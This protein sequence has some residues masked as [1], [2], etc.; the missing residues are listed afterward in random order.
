M[1]SSIRAPRS[2]RALVSPRAQR[3]ASTRLLL[4]LPLGPTTAVIPRSST[5]SVRRAKVLK[6]VT[7]TR[8]NLIRS[9]L[10][11]GHLAIPVHIWGPDMDG[12]Q[13]TVVTAVLHPW[14]AA[15]VDGGAAAPCSEPPA[16]PPWAQD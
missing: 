3:M 5:T 14:W 2:S 10:L 12:P 15:F 11:S 1:T 8:R 7:V 4:P 16:P 13:Y 9:I 6:P